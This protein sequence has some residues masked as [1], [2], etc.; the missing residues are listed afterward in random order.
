MRKDRIAWL[1]GVDQLDEHRLNA[2]SPTR[3]FVARCCHTPMALEFTKGH[4]LSVYAGRI[5]V[6]ERPPT[7]MRTMVRDRPDGVEFSDDVPSYTSHSGKFMWKLLSAWAA[8]GFRAPPIEKTQGWT[9]K[10]G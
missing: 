7:A 4:W 10:Q 1:S 6:R 8:M 3:R 9:R 2:D 5:P